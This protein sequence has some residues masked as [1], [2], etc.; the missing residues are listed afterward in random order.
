M[1]KG[2][3]E[4]LQE[5]LNRVIVIGDTGVGKSSLIN[6]LIGEEVA[7]VNAVSS[8]TTE[9]KPYPLS[10]DVVIIDTR[11]TDEIFKGD[12]PWEEAEANILKFKPQLV[13]WCLDGS[14]RDGID[15]GFEKIEILFENVFKKIKLDLRLAI[16][17]NKVDIIEPAGA[18][19]LPESWPN[20]RTEKG[21]NINNRCKQINQLHTSLSKAELA[22]LEPT[23]LEWYKSAKPWNL[24]DIKNQIICKNND[25]TKKLIG[26]IS[27]SKDAFEDILGIQAQAIYLDAES[28][29]DI[30]NKELKLE[31]ARDYFTK[32]KFKP[33]D[34]KNVKSLPEDPV[35]RLVYFQNILT[36]KPYIKFSE[37]SDNIKYN[38]DKFYEILIKLLTQKG[39]TTAECKD[40]IKDF[41]NIGKL[42]TDSG[43]GWLGKIVLFTLFGGVVAWWLAPV[44][45]AWI[46]ATLFGLSGAAATSA[47]LA[48]L[49]LGSL[50]A[51]GFGMFGG[52]L[53]VIGAG[54]V[55][56]AGSGALAMSA[57]SDTLCPEIALMNCSKTLQIFKF[58]LE[59]YKKD[60]LFSAEILQYTHLF[61]STV[62]ELQQKEPDIETGRAKVYRKGLVIYEKTLDIM[63][64]ERIEHNILFHRERQNKEY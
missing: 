61:A 30:K 25:N 43:W 38:N 45:G 47:G 6:H 2:I 56:A 14:R 13:V 11:G 33:T 29:T 58:M 9:A 23:C 26:K 27:L 41:A 28:D 48:W 42:L 22:I 53:V 64:T 63:E 31:W 4:R 8:C 52:T 39:A 16:V 19:Y 40:F 34:F 60:G 12:K 17:V 36:F 46:G 18:E 20:I 57:L 62:F 32:L 3:N 49:G 54:A 24:D 37:N 44:V 15:Q 7:A 1:N 59:S 55:L 51:G 10:D 21:Q 5:Y 35:Q 50:A